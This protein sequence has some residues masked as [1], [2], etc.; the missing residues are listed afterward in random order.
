M[1]IVERA[2]IELE[3]AGWNTDP[4]KAVK[5]DQFSAAGVHILK[6]VEAFIGADWS[7]ATV[8]IGLELFNALIKHQCLTPI[9]GEDSEWDDMTDCSG[10]ALFQ[11]KRCSSV[12][13]EGVDGRPFT[14]NAFSFTEPCEDDDGTPYRAS[15]T[16]SGF[17]SGY[18]SFPYVPKDPEVINLPCK[19]YDLYEDPDNLMQSEY[20]IATRLR[21]LIRDG[22]MAQLDATHP[23]LA[24]KVNNQLIDWKVEGV[25][26]VGNDLQIHLSTRVQD[27]DIGY[28]VAMAVTSRMTHKAIQETLLG[29][30]GSDWSNSKVVAAESQGDADNV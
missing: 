17:S 27:V 10:Y 12:F 4:D 18:I 29:L 3:A 2:R 7:G 16:T 5:G 6:A 11:N 13:K 26:V 8:G 23:E 24:H 20:A 14:V 30:L 15:F 1:K 25:E 22:F 9:T 21:K 28:Q 19:H